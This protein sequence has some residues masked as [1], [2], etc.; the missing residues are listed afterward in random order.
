[1]KIAVGKQRTGIKEDALEAQIIVNSAIAF[2]EAMKANSNQVDVEE[3]PGISPATVRW[4]I[5]ASE[6]PPQQVQQRKR[7]RTA[8]CG[9]CE[10]FFELHSS[11]ASVQCDRCEKWFALACVG[12]PS[13]MIVTLQNMEAWRCPKCSR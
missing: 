10:S 4:I 2:D 6:P 13:S 9:I 1:M 11:Q 5:K 8:V 7:T 3:I 12:I